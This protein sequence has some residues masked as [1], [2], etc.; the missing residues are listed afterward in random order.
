MCLKCAFS[1]LKWSSNLEYFQWHLNKSEKACHLSAMPV[2]TVFSEHKGKNGK[3]YLSCSTE[4][5]LLSAL[6]SEMDNSVPIFIYQRS[7]SLLCLD[8]Y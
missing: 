8:S 7:T 1:N 5:I 3:N 4:N 2:V 6:G